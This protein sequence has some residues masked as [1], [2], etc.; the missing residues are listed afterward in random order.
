VEK[1][2][3][4]ASAIAGVEQRAGVIVVPLAGLVA[5]EDQSLVKD[6]RGVSTP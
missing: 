5:A 2:Q 3:G 1:L 4:T 6:E